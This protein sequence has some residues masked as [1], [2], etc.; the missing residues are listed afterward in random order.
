MKK[1]FAIFSMLVLLFQAGGFVLHYFVLERHS[2]LNSDAELIYV[3]ISMPYLNDWQNPSIAHIGNQN[4]NTSLQKD[5]KI[6]KDVEIQ[7]SMDAEFYARDRF[8][9][10]ADQ[11]NKYLGEEKSSAPAGKKLILTLASEYCERAGPWV[12]YILEWPLK[13]LLHQHLILSTIN[14]QS[15]V[16]SPPRKA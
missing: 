2:T 11:M 15:D 12:F 4:V 8:S 3:S 5:I 6:L 13:R 1:I 10:L 14:F 9:Q 16:Y 7:T